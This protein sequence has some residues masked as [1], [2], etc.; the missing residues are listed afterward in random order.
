MRNKT[1][2]AIRKAVAQRFRDDRN[3]AILLRQDTSVMKRAYRIS[4][5]R[6]DGN[7]FSEWRGGKMLPA[8]ARVKPIISRLTKRLSAKGGAT[9]STSKENAR[10]RKPPWLSLE[11]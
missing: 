11:K 1:A 4:K 2:R 6:W 5:K 10:E 7:A 8:S 9:N 3:L